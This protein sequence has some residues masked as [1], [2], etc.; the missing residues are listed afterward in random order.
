MN[1]ITTEYWAK[2]IPLRQFDW[3]ASVSGW[4]G[5]P[6]GNG[7]YELDAIDDLLTV[8]SDSETISQESFTLECVTCLGTKQIEVK[9][10]LYGSPSCPEPWEDIPCPTCSA[11]GILEGT[12]EDLLSTLRSI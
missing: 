4:E 12:P 3:I 10:R 9:H 5:K 2:P 8:L 11:R 6:S 7:Q 1:K